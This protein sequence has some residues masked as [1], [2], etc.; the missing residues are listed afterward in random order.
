MVGLSASVGMETW[1]VWKEEEGQ[2]RT[3]Q[4]LGGG[5]GHETL[6]DMAWLDMT[7]GDRDRHFRPGHA[8][9]CMLFAFSCMLPTMPV[10]H[11]WLFPFQTAAWLR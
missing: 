5:Q 8:P 2:D 9:C 11:V 1:T 7:F 4:D 10:L 3:G 6:T